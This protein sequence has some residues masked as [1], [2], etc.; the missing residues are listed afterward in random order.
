MSPIPQGNWEDEMV[1]QIRT[2]QERIGI[3]QVYHDELSVESERCLA[4]MPVPKRTIVLL[5]LRDGFP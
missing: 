3:Q 1:G 2:L 5:Q 4:H